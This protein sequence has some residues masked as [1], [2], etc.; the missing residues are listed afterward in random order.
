MELW[1]LIRAR[2]DLDGNPIWK[3]RQ[4]TDADQQVA[5]LAMNDVNDLCD[6]IEELQDTVRLQTEENIA[7]MRRIFQLKNATAVLSDRAVAMRVEIAM[8]RARVA[9]WESAVQT[10]RLNNPYA[11][12]AFMP[13]TVEDWQRLN[14]LVQRELGH[15]LDR[16][17][18]AMMVQAWDGCTA[19]IETMATEAIEAAEDK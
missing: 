15:G 16:Y 12:D 19:T 4:W 8:L 17:S 5:S 6:E 3:G 14:D 9:A 11:L 18:A 10:A 2:W 13:V 1:K 7:S